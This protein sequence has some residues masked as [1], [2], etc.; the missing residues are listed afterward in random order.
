MGFRFRKSVKIAPGVKIN[1]SKSGM[2]TTIGGKSLFMSI[3]SRGAYLNT[4]IPGTGVSARHKITGG[5]AEANIAPIE[6]TEGRI[7]AIIS[8]VLFV[9]AFVLLMTGHPI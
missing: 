2:S 9:S 1:L 5:E 7:L 6:K 4:G 3:G 8:I